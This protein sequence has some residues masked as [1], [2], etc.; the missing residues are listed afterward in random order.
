[1]FF[2][3]QAGTV[4]W[5]PVANGS[6]TMFRFDWTLNAWVPHGWFP[7]YG[8]TGYN[9]LAYSDIYAA[10]DPVRRR[11]LVTVDRVYTPG[12]MWWYDT[13]G[14]TPTWT[15][16]TNAP[17][18]IL[19]ANSV[20]FD[21]V[22]NVF[23]LVKGLGDGSFVMYAYD[24]AG[25]WHRLTPAGTPP[26]AVHGG[27]GF[28]RSGAWNMLNWDPVHHIFFFFHSIN[29][30]NDPGSGG[31]NETDFETWAFRYRPGN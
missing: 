31:N 8:G 19:N 13:S 9:G 17:A 22:N 23:L 28:V 24:Q 26:I 5:I 14:P 27:S 16:I 25:V 11:H 29:G 6:E 15:R 21:T 1:M 10:Y 3:P 20:A 4:V 2:D 7:Y 12:A 30:S 18:E